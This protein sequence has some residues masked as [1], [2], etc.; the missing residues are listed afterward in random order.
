LY[1]INIKKNSRVPMYEKEAF[2]EYL[3]NMSDKGWKLVE[4]D[5]EDPDPIYYRRKLVFES[6]ESKHLYYGIGALDEPDV[7]KRNEYIQS[8]ESAGWKFV[9]N[10]GKLYIFCSESGM[11]APIP[12]DLDTE[13]EIAEQLKP[14]PMP[15]NFQIFI[16]LVFLITTALSVTVY[17]DDILSFYSSDFLMLGSVLMILAMAATVVGRMFFRLRHKKVCNSLYNQL[18]LQ[19]REYKSTIWKKKACY[20][21]SVLFIIPV[22]ILALINPYSIGSSAATYSSNNIKLSSFVA[23]EKLRKESGSKTLSSLVSFDYY[24]QE[25]LPVAGAVEKKENLELNKE[26][27]KKKEDKDKEDKDKEDKDKEETD[28]GIVKPTSTNNQRMTVLNYKFFSADFAKEVYEKDKTN[29]LVDGKQN[30]LPKTIFTQEEC[31]KLKISM[32]RYYYNE[33]SDLLKIILLSDDTY[34]IISMNLLGGYN[35]KVADVIANR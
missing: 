24:Y 6:F 33:N 3:S 31:K 28:D 11:L 29:N 15:D 35:E 26:E 17:K 4:V 20:A 9:C 25:K 5:T 23:V 32:G 13:A 10:I 8:C 19:S 12:S 18:T 34:T 22:A 7:Q 2:A 30:E 27:D 21:L 16:V 14:S 1:T